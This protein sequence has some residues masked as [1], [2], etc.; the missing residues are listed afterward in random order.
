MLV[1]E[2]EELNPAAVYITVQ[3]TLICNTLV[4]LDTV[5]IWKSEVLQCLYNTWHT[6]KHFHAFNFLTNSKG[7]SLS[8]LD[9][10]I[11]YDVFH[12]FT[13]VHTAN[14]H[15]NDTVLVQ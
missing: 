10:H 5:G 3:S 7:T 6:I 2:K 14:S 13:K 1:N 8:R 11:K 4:Y 15:W 12:S 9:C